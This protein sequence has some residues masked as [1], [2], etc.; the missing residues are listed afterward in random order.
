MTLPVWPSTLPQFITKE[1]FSSDYSNAIKST[2]AYGPPKFRR[3]S[4]VGYETLGVGWKVT[5]DQLDIFKD[6]YHDTL[7][8][9]TEQFTFD[10]PYDGT[11][12][13]CNFMADQGYKTTFM[14][15]DHWIVTAQFIYLRV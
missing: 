13:T 14:G 10:S 5:L 4:T 7:K 11:D 3:R 8:D 6:F 15:G 2:P 9:G 12:I 1:N